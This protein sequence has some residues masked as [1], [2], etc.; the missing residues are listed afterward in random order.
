[1]RTTLSDKHERGPV[2]TAIGALLERI[3]A[4]D[5]ELHAFV[6]LCPEA[7]LASARR[8]DSLAPEQRGPLHGMPIAVKE[9]IDVQGLPCE[10]GSP[11]H[12]GRT[13]ER[14]ATAVQQLQAAGAVVIGISAS[15]EYAIAAPAAT[16]HPLDPLRSPG[17][18]SSGSA[19]AV[20][21]GLLPLAFGTQ[22]IGSIVRPAAYCGAVGFKPS[23]GRYASDGM[24]PLSPELDHLG[25]IGDC[26]DTVA[27]TD[28][29]L[30]A[31]PANPPQPLSGLRF[32][33]TWFDEPLGASVQDLM[34]RLRQELSADHKVLPDLIVPEAVARIE[35]DVTDVLLTRDLAEY[36][37]SDVEAQPSLASARLVEL[38]A[39]GRT[40]S[41][42][43]YDRAR[44]Q[45]RDIMLTLHGLLKPGEV[46]LAP[47]TVDVAPLREHGTG[48]RAPQRLWTLAGMPTLTIPVGTSQ[49]LPL[50]VQLIA[51]HGDDALLLHLAQRLE[52][53]LETRPHG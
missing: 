40:V 24:M 2:T 38:V 29:V 12:A 3:A 48:S 8:L 34:N 53:Q 6:S 7:A 15:M 35:S 50:G 4:R 43:T 19:A 22:T 16:T 1:M 52:A 36:H 42:D 26:V 25:L 51:R 47:A 10:W 32:V 44:A 39:Q 21:A 17:G 20:G 28:A 18:S 30:A 33:R 23:F 41:A 5:T 14:S 49:G 37:G 27:K 46:A 31:G 9:V 13:P 45:R 11:I